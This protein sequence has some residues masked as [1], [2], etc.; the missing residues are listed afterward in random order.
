MNHYEI[1]A[2]VVQAKN[3]N[4]EALLKL[5]NQYKALIFK[6]AYQYDIR[7]YESNDLVQIGYLAIL[8]ALKS[9]KVGSNTF[10]AYAV[11]AIKNTI[12]YTLR[13]STKYEDQLS[14][15]SPLYAGQDHSTEYIDSIVSEENPMEEA[16][17]CQEA[18]E[19]R[20]VLS[21]LLP[22]DLELITAVYFNNLPL[23]HYAR[24]KGLNYLQ[25]IRKRNR[26]LKDL[27]NYIKII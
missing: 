6:T 5:L 25:A 13:Q 14:L 18:L 27:N 15:N 22:E 2:C 10:S 17:N 7:N 19:L 12:K 16:L 4:Q 21:K 24:K 23:K 11:K 3:G 9:Y 26:I 20:T 8:K 1:E